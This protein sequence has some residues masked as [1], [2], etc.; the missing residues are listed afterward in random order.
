MNGNKKMDLSLESIINKK[1]ANIFAKLNLNTSFSN[2]KTSDII[3][4]S[5]RD[6]IQ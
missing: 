3:I 4:K 2:V 5:L 1:M 6:A